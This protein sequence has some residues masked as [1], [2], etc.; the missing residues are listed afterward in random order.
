MS[1]SL[2]PPLVLHVIYRL[3]MGGLE[4]GLVNLINHMPAGRYRHAIVCLTDFTD[5]RERLCSPGVSVL[6]LNKEPGL[7]LSVYRKLWSIIRDMKPMIVH[8]RNLPTFEMAALAAL[9]RVPYRI[10]GEHGRDLHDAYGTNRKFLIFRKV[11]DIA[12]HHYVA[13]SQDLEQW[14]KSMVMIAPKKVSQ[15]YNGV[16]T[17]VF[18]APTQK[19]R[20]V[21]PKGFAS[22]E[23]VVIGTVGRL[24]QVKDHAT[25]IR[26]LASLIKRDPAM[27]DKFRLMIVGDGPLKM[28]LEQLIRESH[29]T[30]MVWMPGARTDIP[31]LL[32]GM[33]IFV[34]PS[35][36][37]GISNTIL[38]AMASGLPVIATRVGGNAELVVE[39]ETGLLVPAKDPRALG[40]ALMTYLQDRRMM[41]SHGEAGRK[42]VETE[43]SM[44][45][46]VEH[47]LQVYDGA[48]GNP[49]SIA[50]KAR[51]EA[52][53]N[54][55]DRSETVVH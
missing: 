8:T 34:L 15:I 43:F 30:D 35:E 52:F 55:D 54:T 14:L 22:S 25:L 3:A 38:E 31:R 48:L 19:G 6:A 1:S 28:E 40:L 32:Q 5:F 42:R 46:M 27:A 50:G 47:Y 49:S 24:Q 2:S 21:F 12:V 7:D 51:Q 20:D 29:L 10:H 37:E 17:Q 39:G 45:A 41:Q 18:Q 13:V 16:D 53:L 11:L 23:Q 44:Q 36:A 9:A 26:G 4:N 33:D